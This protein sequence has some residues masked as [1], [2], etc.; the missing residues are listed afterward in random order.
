MASSISFDPATEHNVFAH[1]ESLIEPGGKDRIRTFNQQVTSG[2]VNAID[3]CL[4]EDLDLSAL[5]ESEKPVPFVDLT[6]SDSD[7]YEPISPPEVGAS[8]ASGCVHVQYHWQTQNIDPT[9]YL[10]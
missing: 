1:T 2:L 7:F 3:R 5:C 9:Q 10:Q 8:H 4:P 6:D